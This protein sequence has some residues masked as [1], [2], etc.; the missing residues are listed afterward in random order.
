[1]VSISMAPSPSA[2]RER[3]LVVGAR[4]FAVFHLGLRDGGAEVDV[5]EGRCLL[6][7]GLAAG[8]VAEERPLAGAARALVDRGVVVAPV[9]RQ[10]E[11]LEELL[12]DQL[13]H[14]DEL[15][16]QFEEVRP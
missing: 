5:P 11:P 12:E 14:L 13:V 7:V 8:D 2:A 15:V 10:P 1:V 16:A 3:D 4:A 6:A 9:D